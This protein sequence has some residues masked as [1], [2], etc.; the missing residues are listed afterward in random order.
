MKKILLALILILTV[1]LSTTLAATGDV[2][3]FKGYK[4]GTNF[5]T[6]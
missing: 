1:S 3:G 5:E 6:I 2:N 4:W